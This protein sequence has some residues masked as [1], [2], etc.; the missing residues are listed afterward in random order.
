MHDVIENIEGVLEVIRVHSLYVTSPTPQP[1]CKGRGSKN[2]NEIIFR[3]GDS[4]ASSCFALAATKV[5]GGR[6][7]CSLLRPYK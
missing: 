4:T 1:P 2:Q 7:R 6:S 5:K 3:G